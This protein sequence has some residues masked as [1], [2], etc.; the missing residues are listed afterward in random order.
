MESGASLRQ[1]VRELLANEMYA[2]AE[3][4]CSFLVGGAVPAAEAS[5]RAESLEL[6]GDALLGAG[7][8]RRAAVYF[9]EAAAEL[10]GAGQGGGGGGGSGSQGVA[11]AFYE[12]KFKSARCALRADDLSGAARLLEAVPAAHRTLPMNVALGKLSR[13]VGNHRKAVGAYSDAVLQAPLALGCVRALL[14][15]GVPAK[16]VLGLL[17]RAAGAQGEMVRSQAGWLKSFVSAH[18]HTAAHQPEKAVRDL[19]ALQRSF[20]ASAHVLL[21]LAQAHLATT[22][23]GAGADA[24]ALFARARKAD[25]RNLD[26]MDEYALLLARQGEGLKLN[27]LVRELLAADEGRPEGWVAAAAFSAT[28]GD[29]KEKALALVDRALALDD[30]HPRAHLYKGSLLLAEGRA[31]E[32][33]E[34]YRAA[35]AIAR[36]FESYKGMVEAYVMIPQHKEALYVA[37]QA[38]QLNP[39]NVRAITLVGRVVAAKDSG[40]DKAMKAL[41]KALALDAT[42]VDAIM[43]MV[44]LHRERGEMAQCVALL[45]RAMECNSETGQAGLTAKLADVYASHHDTHQQALECYHQALS[46]NN[47]N[48][49]AVK[50][51]ARLERLMQGEET[52]E[53][54]D[55]GEGEEGYDDSQD[56]YM[57]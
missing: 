47:Y 6:Y 21:P 24:A 42:C 34:S 53:E 30:A 36:E 54:E 37:K 33:A 52:E 48:E 17:G 45:R 57:Q 32:A 4:L 22:A 8:H 12:L 19:G 51:L 10:E 3:L 16:E 20:P 7:Q 1:Q 35:N 40:A 15:L 27:G 5:A 43:A 50:G 39:K 44:D 29:P 14:Q 38:L 11:A 23:P 56:S 31:V 41:G 13:Q 25:G 46:L 49:E 28:R 55:D 2:D 18:G 9:G 26:A